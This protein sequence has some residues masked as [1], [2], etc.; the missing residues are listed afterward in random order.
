VILRCAQ[1]II[2][3]TVRHAG[4]TRLRLEVQPEGSGV[5]IRS[6]DDGQGAD[7]VAVGNGLRGMRE[8]LEHYG[9]RLA[10]TT[11]R[12]EGFAVNAWL[13]LGRSESA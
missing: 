13:P 5:F 8:R 9:G 6:Q 4:A 1:E 12:G 2:T 11:A 7:A 10:I 3:N